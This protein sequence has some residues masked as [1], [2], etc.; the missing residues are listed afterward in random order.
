MLYIHP[1]IL[2][3][4]LADRFCLQNPPKKAISTPDCLKKRTSSGNITIAK[5]TKKPQNDIAVSA[6]LYFSANRYPNSAITFFKAS[7]V[8]CEAGTSG[9]RSTLSIFPC[10]ARSDFTPAGLPSTDMSLYNS[11]MLR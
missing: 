3:Y 2:N 11:F 8:D 4:L 7:C 6:A 9:K 5:E 1:L 10:K